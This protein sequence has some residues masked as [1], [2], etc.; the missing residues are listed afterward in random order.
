MRTL[1]IDYGEKRI[2]IAASDE[3]E[4][5]AFEIGIVPAENFFQKLPEIISER[6]IQKIVLGLPLN[7]SAEETKKTK[8]VRLFADRLK[9]WL[10][11]SAPEIQFDFADERLSSQMASNLSGS[12]KNIDGLAAQ[13]I[14][15]NYLERQSNLQKK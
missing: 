4:K 8:E 2:G 14:L 7:M 11:G 3:E 10:K 12:Q 15:Q 6:E 9:E 1:G 13:V 5:I